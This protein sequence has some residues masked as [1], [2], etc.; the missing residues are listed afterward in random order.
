MLEDLIAWFPIVFFLDNSHEKF[1]RLFFLLK[2]V[3]IARLL[4]AFDIKAIVRKI[5]YFTKLA[6]TMKMKNDPL[7]AEDTLQDHNSFDFLMKWNHGLQ[8]FKLVIVIIN[9]SYFVGIVFML[10]AE[11]NM[12]IARNNTE[13]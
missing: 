1:F 12:T 13:Y 5:K 6:M 10:V 8:I 9:I 3:R 2:I 7:I 11:V 4:R